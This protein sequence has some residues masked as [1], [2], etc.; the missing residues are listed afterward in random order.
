MSGRTLKHLGTLILTFLLTFCLF[1]ISTLCIVRMTVMQPDFTKLQLRRSGYVTYVTKSANTAIVN[2][3]LGSGVPK[4]VFKSVPTKKVVTQDVAY[5]VDRAYAGAGIKLPAPKVR[6]ALETKLTA[7]E[8]KADLTLTKAQKKAVDQ[9]IDQ[10]VNRYT[11]SIQ[12]PYLNQIGRN[13]R[14]VQRYLLLTLI[15][16]AVLGLIL[17]FSLWRILHFNHR[18]WRYLAYALL[19]NGLMLIIGPV[20][21]IYSR[22]IPRLAIKTQGLYQFV[23]TY[24]QAITW[25]FVIAGLLSLVLGLVATLSSELKRKQ[26]LGG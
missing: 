24:L 6:Q 21:L 11:N 23:T 17:I 18:L 13:A 3:G 16:V 26:R 22:I 25:L 5:F 19:A 2:L 20:A 12:I 7:Y 10:A 8:K 1:V 9:L 4:T 14:Q 15:G